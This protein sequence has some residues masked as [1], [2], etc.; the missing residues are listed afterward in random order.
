MGVMYFVDFA[1]G[2]VILCVLLGCIGVPDVSRLRG[3]GD[4]M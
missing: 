1:M 4:H 2:K 3:G